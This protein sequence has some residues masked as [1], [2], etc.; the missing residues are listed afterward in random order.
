MGNPAAIPVMEALKEKRLRISDNDALIILNEAKDKGY[1]ALT[2]QP[3]ELGS[4]NLRKPRINNAV[5]RLL[6]TAIG[7]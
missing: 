2:G 6:S 4:L 7:N 3:V 5:R 1:D